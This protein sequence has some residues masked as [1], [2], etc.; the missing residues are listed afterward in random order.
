MNDDRQ[1]G[2]VSDSGR[3]ALRI[4]IAATLA[5]AGLRGALLDTGRPD[6]VEFVLGALTGA[7]VLWIAW[8]A[9][10]RAARAARVVPAPVWPIVVALLL[11]LLVFDEWSMAALWRLA[12]DSSSWGWPLPPLDGLSVPA[13]ASIV[14]AV[15]L[16]TIVIAR[17]RADALALAREPGGVPLVAVAAVAIAAAF[18][19]I[20]SLVDDGGDPYPTRFRTIGPDVP[21]TVPQIQAPDPS[22]PGTHEF[23]LLSYGAGPNP[24][25]PEYA[26]GR[27]LDSRTVDGRRLLPEWRGLR[28]RA[29]EDYWDFDLAQAPLNA[30]L[31]APRGDGPFPLVLIVHGNHGMEDVSDPGYA[32]LGEFLA[33]RGYL[34][35]SVDENF[36]NGSW[37]GDFRGK[38][39]A[40]RA[41]LLLEHLSLW[42]DWNATPGHRFEGRVD[43]ER[44]AL[45]GHS[46]GG[47]A[48]SI[49]HAFNAL[50]RH[51]DDATI[52]FDYGFDIDALVAVAQVDQ[53]YHRRV[54]LQDVNFL[55]LQGSYDADEPAFH[56]LRQFNR[57]DLSPGSDRFKAGFY[58]HRANHGQFNAGWGR[59]D[60]GPPGAWLLNLEPIIDGETQRRIASVTIASFLEATLNGDRRYRALFRDPRRGASW[61][62]EGIYLH[63]YTDDTFVPI[64]DFEEDLDV[65]TGSAPGTTIRTE[66]L[67]LWRE[68]SLMHRD[69]RAQGSAAV[70]LGWRA[71]AAPSYTIDL[72][73]GVPPAADGEA[74]LT[75]AIAPSPERAKA[76][77]SGPGAVDDGEPSSAEE[78]A[79]DERPPARIGDASPIEFEVELMHRDGTRRRVA[80]DAFSRVAPPLK[81]RYLKSAAANLDAY[82]NLWEAVLQTVELP[83]GMAA[84]DIA[85]ITLHLDGTRDG[86]V[87]VD[88]I[89]LRADPEA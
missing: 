41:W 60:Y 73:N 50:D 55:A 34:V 38:E 87:I 88:A 18:A 85:A 44:I 36:I 19:S 51:P 74:V 54:E 86:T 48:V 79:A 67:A 46:R 82:G 40:I 66:G 53:R 1:D 29:R 12:L 52:A 2:S 56:G 26:T 63:Q 45:V 37:T 15:S 10:S 77:A 78:G 81:V 83:L 43:L 75:L 16:G 72:A 33:S 69:G 84:A 68:E 42:R 28:G 11:T 20:Y 57:I 25:R 59:K 65:T 70:V 8:F 30:L 35:A 24:R 5:I 23:D 89:G 4:A 61:L 80:A 21:V 7:A 32:Y 31:W 49:A 39:M 76:T 3:T 47:E 71:G 6:S 62:P 14:L 22:Q 9:G 27:D 64:A 58:I 13:L 17:S